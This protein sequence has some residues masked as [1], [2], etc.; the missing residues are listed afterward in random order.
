MNATKLLQKLIQ[1]DSQC[2]KSNKRI[3]DFI[4]SLFPRQIC[5]ITKL[6]KGD[7]NLFN[8]QIK[9]KG[10]KHEQPL[11]FSGHTDTVPL[12]SGWT[13]NP[14]GGQI[15]GRKIYGLGASDMKAGLAAMILTALSI[16]TQPEQDVLFLFDADEEAGCVGGKDFV[17]RLKIRP[18]SA[19]IIVAEPS[20]G[21]LKIGQKGACELEIKFSG[22][23]FHSSLSDYKKNRQFNAIHKAFQAFKKIESLEKELARKRMK[24]FNPPSLAVCQIAGGVA[25]NVIP[26][27]C[28]MIL[29][30]RFLPSEDMRAEIKKMICLIKQAD[31]KA[32]VKITFCGE[33]NL[34]SIKN[35]LL[36]Q[37]RKISRAVLGK[38]EI[39]VT[40][41]WTQ[42]GLFKKWGDCL[43][44]GPGTMNVAHQANEYCD[45]KN[46]PLMVECY[47]QLI[48][49]NV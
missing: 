44:W 5:K 12:Q 17:H 41:G 11:I 49:T 40:Q 4:I 42:A 23:A 28:A 22:K 47:K 38:E 26:D 14:F 3:V 9:F 20:A 16:K 6:K 48:D 24:M 46:I 7:L 19:K 34:L 36:K 30:R 15:V 32:K 31:P 35:P 8:L 10:K 45:L 2:V 27:S 21:A 13:K 1:I 39:I 33:P 18:R 43:I 37:A 25:P 29:S